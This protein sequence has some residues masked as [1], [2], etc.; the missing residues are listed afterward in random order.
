MSGMDA[1]AISAVDLS[2]Q[3]Q[4]C[5]L[6]IDGGCC[7]PIVMEVAVG[8]HETWNFVFRGDRAPAIVNPFTGQRKVKT[9]INVRMRLGIVG[10]LWK[11]RARHHDTCGVDAARFESFGCCRIHRMSHADV[12]GMHDQKLGIARKSELLSERFGGA[13]R[14]H[15][16]RHG[17]EEKKQE[18]QERNSF[19]IH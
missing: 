6:W 3:L 9:E 2:T 15:C 11:P 19:S 17:N 14:G 16:G 4:L 5:F 12:V 13:L 1:H 18:K 7:R 10:D 8:V